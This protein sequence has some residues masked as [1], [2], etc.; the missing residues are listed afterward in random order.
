[1]LSGQATGT[2]RSNL[3]WVMNAYVLLQA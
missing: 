3:E 1:V 2:G